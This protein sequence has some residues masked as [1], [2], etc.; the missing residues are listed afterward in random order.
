MLEIPINAKRAMIPPPTWP[1][2]L[3]SKRDNSG[4][5][6]ETLAGPAQMVIREVKNRIPRVSFGKSRQS[7]I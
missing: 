7:R 5:S 6:D 1:K 2:A 3:K 4:A